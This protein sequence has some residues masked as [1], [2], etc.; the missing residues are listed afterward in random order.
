MT[1]VEE[2]TP[3]LGSNA[4]CRVLGLWRGAPARQQASLRRAAFVGPRQPR[5]TR[6]PPPLALDVVENQALLDTL[7]SECQR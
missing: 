3:A 2:L 1:G 5:V 4:A 6:P 7:N